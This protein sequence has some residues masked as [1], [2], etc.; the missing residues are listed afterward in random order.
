MEPQKFSVVQYYIK[1][2]NT[3]KRGPALKMYHFKI[4]RIDQNKGV[5]HINFLIFM[6]FFIN[7]EIHKIYFLGKFPAIQY[8]T[9][10]EIILIIRTY[11]T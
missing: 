7:H 11:T 9:A 6:E 3:C 8:Y 4:L 2:N 1:S 5:N 10:Y